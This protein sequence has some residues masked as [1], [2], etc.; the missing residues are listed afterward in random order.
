MND[1]ILSLRRCATFGLAATSSL[2]RRMN[3]DNRDIYDNDNV[4]P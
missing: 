3:Y 1:D 4:N 2:I